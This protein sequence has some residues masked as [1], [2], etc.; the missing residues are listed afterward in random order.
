MRMTFT[1]DA[2]EDAWAALERDF[3]QVV[4]EPR[5]MELAARRA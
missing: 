3:A 1:L 2:G 4:G 5:D